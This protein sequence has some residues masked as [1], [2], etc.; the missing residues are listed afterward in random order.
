MMVILFLIR[1]LTGSLLEDLSTL[2]SLVLILLTLSMSQFMSA[3]RTL[4][5]TAVNPIIRY[6][7]ATF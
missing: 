5:L 1:R 2:R 6:V 4:H 3:P 7:R